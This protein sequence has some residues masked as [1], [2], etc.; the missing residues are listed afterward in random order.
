MIRL[1]EI[2]GRRLLQERLHMMLS[3]VTLLIEG[4]ISDFRKKY[5]NIPESIMDIFIEGDPSG[6]NKYL[7]WLGRVVTVRMYESNFTEEDAQNL[8]NW[9]NIFHKKGRGVDIYSFKDLD[10]FIEYIS[11]KDK[12]VSKRDAI[13]SQATTLFVNDYIR[14]VAPKTHEASKH[15]GG[16]TRWCIS[17]SSEGFW[18]QYY[19]EQGDSIVFVIFRKQKA[20][21]AIVGDD[22][23]HS[24]IYDDQDN[25]LA[26]YEE[27]ELINKLQTEVNEDGENAWD[28]ITDHFD[29]DDRDER[30]SAYEEEKLMD[31]FEDYGKKD[32]N[33]DFRKIIAQEMLK[34]N[35]DEF[36]RE[37]WDEYINSA[38]GNSENYINFLRRVWYGS[39][40]ADGYDSAGSIVDID[41]VYRYDEHRYEDEI[42]K[43]INLIKSDIITGTQLD[44]IVKNVLSVEA[45]DHMLDYFYEEYATAIRD[46]KKYLDNTLNDP[47]QS[48]LSFG[49]ELAPTVKSFEEL[50]KL[51]DK[52]GHHNMAMKIAEYASGR[53]YSMA[54][55]IAE[56]ASGR[57]Y[58]RPK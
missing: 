35:D 1:H 56:Y 50:V 29:Y 8:M 44:E 25:T 57:R 46:V 9:I 58:S 12:E 21:Y 31:N 48:L 2:M 22:P 11:K 47:S 15:F 24:T 43:L 40:Y 38:F 32:L 23:K 10:G 41:D 4:R 5:R 7:D 54:I 3:K 49:G 33:K 17:T 27:N 14:V 55:K 52:L 16:S 45:Y 26:R 19:C 51:M 30:K 36:I 20:K 28:A 37:K 6:V 34:L 13:E 42:Q 39:A 18:K 53:R